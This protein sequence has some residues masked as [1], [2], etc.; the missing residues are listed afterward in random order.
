MPDAALVGHRR[1]LL[2]AVA[3]LASEAPTFDTSAFPPPS[4]SIWEESMHPWLGLPPRM[5]HHRQ[6]RPPTK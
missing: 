5:E 1:R 4:D 3:A 6:G 2:D